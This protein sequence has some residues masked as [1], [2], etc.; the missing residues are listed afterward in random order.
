[1]LILDKCADEFD[2]DYIQTVY[3]DGFKKNVVMNDGKS[4]N[5]MEAFKELISKD[6]CLELFKDIQSNKKVQMFE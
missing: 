1:V 2:Q 3:C 4:K 6:T 5:M